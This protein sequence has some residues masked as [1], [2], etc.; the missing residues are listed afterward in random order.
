MCSA[1]YGVTEGTPS[2]NITV[3]RNGVTPSGTV[4]VNYATSNGSAIAGSDYTA[5]SA[6]PSPALSFG[7]ADTMM[8]FMV[9]INNDII[10]EVPETVNLAI[11]GPTGGATLGAQSTAVLTIT[12]NDGGGLV[13][14]SGNIQQYSPPTNTN[15]SGVTVTLSG[16]ASATTMTDV[17][18]NYTF[19][20]LT[21]GGNFLVTPTLAG[22]V[23][24]PINRS[25]G[26]LFSSVSTANFVA[27]N[28][29]NVPRTLAVVTSNTVPG[30]PVAVPI[31]LTGLGNETDLS[32]SLSYNPALMAIT[33]ASQVACG[34][35]AI[36]CLLTVNFATP[37]QLGITLEHPTSFTAG[38]TQAVV[39]TFNTTVNPPNT[40]SNTP[41]TFTDSPAIREVNDVDTNPLPSNYTNA[42]VI[43]EQGL[44]SDV[45]GRFTGN[46][47]VTPT[48]VIQ[49]R[50]FSVGLD[51]TNNSFNEF[52]RA[53]AAPIGTLGNGVITSSDV[54]QARRYQIGTDPTQ[55]AGGPISFIP[56][57][58]SDFAKI[59]KDT[60]KA[61]LPRV[62]RVI[63]ISSSAGSTVVVSVEVDAEGDES[64]YG[65]S[66]DYN[67]SNSINPVLT[68]PVVA[69]GSGA[70][71]GNVLANTTTH[72]GKI[73]FSVDFGG[74]TIPAGNNRQL[75]TVTFNV[76]NNALPGQAPINFGNTPAFSEISNLAAQ[77]VPANYQNGFINITGPTS[78]NASVGG[79]LV[80]GN[81][82]AIGKTTVTIL[83]ENG[84]TKSV[85]TNSFGNYT[86]TDLPVG[87]TYVI[88][89]NSKKYRFTPETRTVTVNG[90][91]TDIDFTAENQ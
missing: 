5:T 51:A 87:Q 81:G 21:A 82:S 13:F 56:P 22:K 24:E 33:S 15:L 73:G 10:S 71:G 25:Y 88:S 29:G 80:D 60:D 77:P 78:A 46:G 32:F 79:R 61:L 68:N 38:T 35:G 19:S 41:V 83:A 6:P 23:F 57:F 18:G 65:F 84:A 67:P 45:I 2:A 69:I 53:D 86:F 1:T 16:S 36:G 9:P 43:F 59:L 64:L 76:A 49:V 42:L 37:G 58:T 89:V 8:S 54:A 75:V 27:Y 48:D 72:P 40:A 34:S 4:T 20:G 30:S 39:I 52:Q 63:P 14:I 28:T 74:S 70:T 3:C 31:N 91:A 55:A 85:V 50:R 62:V 47:S 44:E 26:S 66:L 17:N 7:P 11:S 12:D 90:D